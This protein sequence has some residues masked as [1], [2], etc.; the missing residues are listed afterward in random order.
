MYQNT[1]PGC[2][3]LE[4]CPGGDLF[5]LISKSRYFKAKN[6]RFYGA[7]I[8]LALEYLHQNSILFKDLKSENV[9]ISS[10]GFAKLIDFSLSEH[11]YSGSNKIDYLVANQISAPEVIE[12][13]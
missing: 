8:L 4:Y 3:I 11:Q 6:T 7:C 9:I 12:S 2:L 5:N 13:S 10:E 1:E